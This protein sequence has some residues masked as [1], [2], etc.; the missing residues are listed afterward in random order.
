M[1]KFGMAAVKAVDV[2]AAATVVVLAV[3]RAPQADLLA[4]AFAVALGGPLVLRRRAPVPVL[5][6]VSLASAVSVVLGFG[7][8]AALLAAVLAL[9]PVALAGFGAWGFAGAAL[10]VLG[11]GVAVVIVPGLPIVPAREG[12]ESFSTTPIATMSY[13]FMALAGSWALAAFVR[14]RKSQEVELA[15]LRTERAVAEER[16]R[17]ARDIHDVVGHNLSLIAMKAAVATHLAESHPDEGKAALRTIEQVSRVAL[18]DVRAVLGAVRDSSAS[19]GLDQLVEDARGAGVTVTASQCDLSE[20]PAAT[21][22]SAYRIVQEALTNVRR[23]CS[24]PRCRLTTAVSAGQIVITVVNEGSAAATGPPGHG[25][26]GMRE[27]VALHGGV[28]EVGGDPFT[29][30]AT[31]PFESAV[32]FEEVGVS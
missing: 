5:A 16:L 10:C 1:R 28:L 15:E 2:L 22:I 3:L 20:V 6:V 14:V 19:A 26:L 23:H 21:R 8:E 12:V 25:L 13:C 4:W 32:P 31:V 9:Y 18:N 7:T 17:I 11:A 29:V 27:R 24:P 30:R